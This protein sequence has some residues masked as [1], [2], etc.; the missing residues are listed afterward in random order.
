[1]NRW[2]KLIVCCCAGVLAAA[3]VW[4]GNREM[5]EQ[6]VEE[7][8]ALNRSVVQQIP[9]LPQNGTVKIKARVA[10]DGKAEILESEVI[11]P[12]A[13]A[14]TPPVLKEEDLPTVKSAFARR[15]C[16]GAQVRPYLDDNSDGR[17]PRLRDALAANFGQGCI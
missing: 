3:P 12:Q 9:D 17:Y 2:L 10:P 15:A 13:P 7:L 11:R 4:G 1:M 8:D 6:R 14:K 16:G 5:I